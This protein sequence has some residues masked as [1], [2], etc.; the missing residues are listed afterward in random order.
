MGADG[1]LNFDT[2]IS[3]DGFSSGVNK[4]GSIAKTGMKVLST[5]VISGVAAFAAL[6]KASLDSVASLEQNVGGIETL[7]GAGGKS[8][9]EYAKSV[10]KSTG[11]AKKEYEQLIEAQNL[12]LENANNAYKTA[13]LSANEYMSTVT[14]FAASLKQSVANEVEAAKVADQAVIDMSDN[15]NKMGT[16]MELIQNA[17]QGFA[18]QNYTMLD[19]LKLGYGGTKTEMQRLLKDAEKLSGVKYDINNLADV[20][21]AI[22]V[23]QE[24]LGITGTTA[25]EA[26]ETIEGSMNMA[27]AAWDNFLNGTGT[28]EEFADAVG[29]VA[30]NIFKNLGVIVPRLLKAIPKA[31]IEIGK[32]LI[33]S[34]DECDLTGIGLSLLEDISQGI[35]DNAP[36]IFEKA[37]D[38]SNNFRAGIIESIPSVLATAEEMIT[39]FLQGIEEQLPRLMES[40]VNAGTDFINGILSNIP[41]IIETAGTITDSLVSC[42]I[43][44]LP[45]VLQCGVELLLNIVNG[46]TENSPAIADAAVGVVDKL[47]GTILDN[48]PQMLGSGVELLEQLVNGIIDN[49]PNLISTAIGLVVDLLKTI[50]K[51]APKLIEAG[52]ELLGKLAAGLIRAIPNLLSKIP[53][54]IE[55]IRKKFAEIDWAEVGKN[56]IQGIAKGI[57]KFASNIWSAIKDVAKGALDSA[58]K[59][60]DINSPSRRFRDEVGKMMA[61]GMGIGFEDNI[62]TED[63]QN[64]INNSVKKINKS[65]GTMETVSSM[66]KVKTITAVSNDPGNDNT[67]KEIVIHTHVDLDGKEVGYSVTPYVDNNLSDNED[68]KRRGN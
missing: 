1:S 52:F 59:E 24:E 56:I 44:T 11:Q 57:T 27:K 15:A 53:G 14:S 33:S 30:D 16:N 2:K 32:K 68:L 34:F 67:S 5:A 25:K 46:I 39:S 58:K 23:I 38:F 9:E 45:K 31:A 51:H 17:Y 60:L 50:L 29:H 36:M 41:A 26:T 66:E 62:P 8:L 37:M 47:L 55:D 48:A 10:G 54:I 28:A 43:S 63:M 13:G 4:L 7:F 64:S 3:T 65:V 19:N 18:K 61:L 21:N 22:H 12:A 6:T 35:Q 40:G 20:Y 49:L 42:I